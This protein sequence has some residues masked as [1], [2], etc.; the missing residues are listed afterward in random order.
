LLISSFRV[1]KINFKSS[2]IRTKVT[3]KFSA[4]GLGGDNIK[5]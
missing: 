4:F 2:E 1:Q 5:A 3:S